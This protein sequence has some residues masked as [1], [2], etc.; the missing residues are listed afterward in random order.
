MSEK[1][2]DLSSDGTISHPKPTV[3]LV[4]DHDTHSKQIIRNLEKWSY[5]V[6]RVKSYDAAKEHIEAGNCY[7]AIICDYN[8][9]GDTTAEQFMGWLAESKHSIPLIAHSSITT[10]NEKM[11]SKG[12]ELQLTIHDVPK[13]GSGSLKYTEYSDYLAALQEALHQCMPDVAAQRTL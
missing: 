13:S 3:L 5:Q 4:E 6:E 2:S 11:L 9:H 1:I 8:V 12:Q 7:G 10:N